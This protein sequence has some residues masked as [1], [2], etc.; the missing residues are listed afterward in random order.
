MADINQTPQQATVRDDAETLQLADLWALIWDNKWWYVLSV[1]LCLFIA[2]FHLYKTPK[3]YS[4][5]EKVIVDEDSQATAMKELTA[6]A[7]YRRSFNSGNNVDNELEAFASPDLM[8]KVIARLGYETRYVEKQILRTRE[9]FTLTPVEMTLLGDNTSSSFSFSLSKTGE[10]SFELTDFKVAGEVMA[11]VKISGHLGDSLVTPVGALRFTP[12]VHIEKWERPIVVSWV[13]SRAMGKAYAGR[14]STSLSSKQSSVVVL[15]FSDLFPARAEAVLSTLLDIYNE[16]WVNNKN[17]SARNTADFINDRL[18]VI[19]KELGG[20]E[21]SLKDYKQAHQL[22]NIQSISNAYL[23]QSSE[24]S[25]RAFEVNNQLSVAR[26]IKDYLNNPIHSRDLIP[27]NSGLQNSTVESQI[28][29]YNE[30]LLKRDR[31]LNESSENSPLV[32]DLNVTLEAIKV[33]VNRSIDNYI[34]T[35]Q[36]QMDKISDEERTIM[37]RIA[38]T[39]GQELELL[40]IERQQKVKEQLYVFLLQKREEN[41]LQSLLTVSNTRLIQTPTGSPAPVSPNRM[42][43]LLIA[44]VLGF[45]VP[46]AA[47][48]LMKVLDTSVKGRNDLSRI[49]V[50]FLAEI[51]EIRTNSKYLGKLR[52]NRFDETNTKVM[53]RS[54]SRDMVNEAFRVLRTNLDLMVGHSGSHTIMVTSFNPGAGKTFTMLNL[55]ASVALKGSKVIILDLDLRKATLSK[56]VGKNNTGIASY[57]NGKTDSI[58]DHVQTLGE[59]LFLLSVGSLPPNPAELLV[60][61]R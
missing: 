45:G 12:T 9:L 42:M 18:V 40:S 50:P 54:G 20:V 5:V 49:S 15:T 6:F 4:R 14:L 30:A 48:Y 39:S 1:L 37:R 41:E 22:T 61:D 10:D 2:G 38:S 36:L 29:E 53:V 16:E 57:L 17:R 51:P 58:E 52:S 47:F 13:N 43:I 3:I 11:S 25:T 60:S 46:F 19:E 7:G 8:Q 59:N 28:K 26:Y 23:Q 55:A 34:S 56:A 24:Y 31:L 33:A 35:L 27:A 44:L 32:I 21:S